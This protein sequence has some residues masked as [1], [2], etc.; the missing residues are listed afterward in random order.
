MMV[1]PLFGFHTAVQLAGIG[2]QWV[3]NATTKPS[4]RAS[5]TKISLKADLKASIIAAHG[6]KQKE[7]NGGAEARGSKFQ[8]QHLR[9]GDRYIFMQPL[10]S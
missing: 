8:H 7:A 5:D 1:T 4:F 2:Q 6:T 10:W 3:A 9:S